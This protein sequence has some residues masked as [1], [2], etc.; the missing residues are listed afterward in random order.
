MTASLRRSLADL[1]CRAL[2]ATLPPSLQSWG[3]A[4]R[5]ETTDIP[6]DTRALCFALDSLFGLMPHAIAAQLLRPFASLTG[7]GTPFPGGSLTM[8]AFDAAMHRPR[9]LG[10]VCATGAVGLGLA[11]MIS[12]AAP[13][14]YLAI[15][16][17]ALAIGLTMLA[18]LGRPVF[19]RRQW[20]GGAIIAMAAALLATAL[21]GA[22]VDGAAR[23]VNLGGL[24]IQPSL[25]LLPVMLAA[26]S[27]TR[28]RLATTG[29]VVAAAAMAHQPDRAM[30]VMLASGL[31]ALAVTRP[32]R[33][34]ILAFS[35]ALVA[36]AATLVR[37]D[38][39]PAVPYVDQIFYSSFDVHAAAGMAVLGGAGLLL[40]P[41]FVGWRRDAGNRATY[42]AFG[43][44]WFAV[45]V[46]AALGNYPT[47]VVG[48]GGSAIIGYALS[49]LGLP[50][51]AG[52]PAAIAPGTPG[53][54][55]RPQ[56]D[57][58]LLA[59]LA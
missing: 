41:A 22:R 40:V 18:L 50:K 42:A 32:D 19:E 36:F 20:A 59:G 27:R 37:A 15:N 58:H 29:I 55:G 16:I 43:A 11:Y 56:A 9:A 14:R 31:A 23:W 45:I 47:P 7:D 2:L 4:V 44:A 8:K 51:L 33:H 39:L 17:A 52:A 3:W 38:T 49:L 35:A 26:F 53:A 21:L 54:L 13:M 25:I 30:A 6:D 28:D 5:R 1:A 12:A 48:Y 34:V 57:R 24:A 10:M 46:A